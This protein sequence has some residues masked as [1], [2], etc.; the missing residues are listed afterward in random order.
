MEEDFILI[1]SCAFKA[2]M[3]KIDRIDSFILDIQKENEAKKKTT[4]KLITGKEVIELMRIS[5]QTLWR[6]RER[7]DIN[8][9][10]Q[11]NICLYSEQEV[12]DILENKVIR[13]RKSKPTLLPK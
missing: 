1:E 2:I 7:G 8:Y 13:R 4:G 5:K 9:I 3:N 6:M 11:G 10:K 12:K